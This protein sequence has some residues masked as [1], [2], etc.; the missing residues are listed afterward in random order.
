MAA[1]AFL[2]IGSV[3][4]A[5]LAR[6]WDEESAMW[7]QDLRWNF[8]P[9]RGRLEAAFAEG[10]LSGLVASDDLG[11]CAYATYA[12]DGDRGVV[13]SVFSAKRARGRGT[14][15]LLVYRILNHLQAL[16]PRIIDCQTLFSSDPRLRE[17]FTAQGFESAARV[18]MTIE[19]PVWLASRAVPPKGPGSK[20]THRTDLRAVSRLVFEAHRETRAFDASSSFDTLDSC[21]KILGQIVVDEVC[22]PFDSMGS[23]RIEVDGLLVAASLL[24]WPLPGVA[25]VSEVATSASHRRLGLARRCL[26]ESLQSA[27]ERSGASSA[28]LS[29]TA[30]NHAALALYGSV[31]FVPR[32]RYESHVLRRPAR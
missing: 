11:A 23:R 5:D 10:T 17:P 24:T 4:R 8:A 9:T 22:G 19:R 14:E 16:S 27:F 25:H 32:I 29:V 12:V 30:S 20:P 2:P 28:T 6:L 7:A 26:Y 1:S 3:P 13:G 15:A 21:E 18:Y 31:G